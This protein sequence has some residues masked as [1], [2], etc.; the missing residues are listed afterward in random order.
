[1]NYFQYKLLFILFLVVGIVLLKIFGL[2]F[3]LSI[4][5]LIIIYIILIKKL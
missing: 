4:P 3:V 1:M 2:Y 5:I